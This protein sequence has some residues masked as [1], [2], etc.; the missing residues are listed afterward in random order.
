MEREGLI[1][2]LPFLK[3]P[4]SK[5]MI[6]SQTETVKCTECLC[7]QPRY[8]I[9]SLT[10]SIL[11][12]YLSDRIY[13][14]MLWV[15]WD[16]SILLNFATYCK[17]IKEVESEPVNSCMIPWKLLKENCPSVCQHILDIFNKRSDSNKSIYVYPSSPVS[18]THL[19]RTPAKDVP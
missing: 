12:G 19:R 11:S 6:L 18:F 14:N 9:L 5:Q 1:E 3:E 2:S 17:S 8:P 10:C 16:C 15:F 4:G 13:L 7:S